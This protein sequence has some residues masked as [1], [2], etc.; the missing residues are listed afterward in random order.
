MFAFLKAFAEIAGDLDVGQVLSDIAQQDGTAG[1]H[2]LLAASI[3]RALSSDRSSSRVTGQISGVGNGGC[4]SIV[5][6]N[7]RRASR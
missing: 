1:R 2:P 4:P 6:G 5:S 3:H 7:P